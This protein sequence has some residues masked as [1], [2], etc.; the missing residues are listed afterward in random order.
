MRQRLITLISTVSL[1]EARKVSV[2][3]VSKY[4]I[5]N[6]WTHCYMLLSPELIARFFVAFIR[7]GPKPR[8]IGEKQFAH[9]SFSRHQNSLCLSVPY[10]RF[11]QYFPKNGAWQRSVCQRNYCFNRSCRLVGISFS[12]RKK[13]IFCIGFVFSSNLTDIW[14]VAVVDAHG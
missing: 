14:N 13:S 11:G 2:W 1:G 6:F 7:W 9:V 10:A 4:H 3:F 8:N 12:S 5:F